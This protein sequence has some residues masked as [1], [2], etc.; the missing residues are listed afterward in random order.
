MSRVCSE[1]RLQ[2]NKIGLAQQI[3]EDPILGF[4]LVLFLRRQPSWIGVDDFHLKAAS[5]ACHRLTNTAEADEAKCPAGY[6]CAGK[7]IRLRAG[8]DSGTEK[9]V[10]KRDVARDGKQE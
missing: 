9:S 3:V 6:R 10:A 8:I 7:V 2:R 5:A 4:E 1:L